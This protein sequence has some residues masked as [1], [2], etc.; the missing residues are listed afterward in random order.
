MKL[1]E[2]IKSGLLAAGLDV[3]PR[4][5]WQ[6]DHVAIVEGKRFHQR[7]DGTFDMVKVIGHLIVNLPAIVARREN[8]KKIEAL[9]QALELTNG[10]TV[11]VDEEGKFC[12]SVSGLD[13]AGVRKLV[14]RLK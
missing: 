8:E 6:G 14:A 7:R 10:S 5:V 13:E 11:T 9:V 3:D 4:I 1:E 2:A 12:F